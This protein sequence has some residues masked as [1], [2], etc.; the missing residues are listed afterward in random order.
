MSLRILYVGNDLALL[1]YLQNHLEMKV[2]GCA[3]RSNAKLLINGINYSAI[4]LDESNGE[5]EL[6]IRGVK[7]HKKTPVLF[8]RGSPE[9]IAET[10]RRSLKQ[11]PPRVRKVLS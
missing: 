2:V 3:G 5:L 4:V 7:A 10:V 1:T 6:F 8:A 11:P 9:H